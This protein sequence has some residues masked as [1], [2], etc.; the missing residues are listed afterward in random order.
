ML[1]LRF[2]KLEGLIGKLRLF[3]KRAIFVALFFKSFSSLAN[4]SESLHYSNNPKTQISNLKSDIIYA[5]SHFSYLTSHIL[6][7]AFH[8][9]ITQIEF[10]SKAK[11][12]EI[13]V[14]LFTDDFETAID[15]ENKTK[16]TKILDGDK[17][18]AKVSAYISRHFTIT[19]PQNKKIVF[20][21]IG[22]ENEDLATWIYLEL[23]ADLLTKGCKIQQIAMLE[24]FD[25]QVN[26]LNFRQGEERKTLLFDSKNKLKVWE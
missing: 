16:G 3:F 13:S 9:S 20:K 2:E 4:F 24:L 19:S 21:Y 18:D 5:K 6:K 17:N 11:T 1:V 15:T 26:I 14:R 12:Y 22:K 8:T 7:H 10:N 25:D 23:P